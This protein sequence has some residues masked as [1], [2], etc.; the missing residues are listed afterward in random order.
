MISSPSITVDVYLEVDHPIPTPDWQ[1]TDWEIHLQ[2]WSAIW[3]SALADSLPTALGYEYTVRLT[4]DRQIQEFNA[5]YRNLDRPTDVLSFPTLDLNAPAPPIHGDEPFYL[6]DIIISL[7]TA[8]RQ[9]SDRGHSLSVEL[10]WLLTHGLLHLLGWDHPDEAS[11]EQML[12][13]QETLLSLAGLDTQP[14][15]NYL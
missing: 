4:G 7:E 9:G 1:P 12:R 15:R 11:L 3:L 5:Q 14:F 10:S 2:P 13:Q 6:G 8:Q